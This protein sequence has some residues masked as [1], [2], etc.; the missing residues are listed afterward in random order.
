MPIGVRSGSEREPDG[1]Q[2]ALAIGA[3]GVVFGDIG[4]SP[5]Y[6]I[7]TVFNPGDP[8]PI[9]ATREGVFGVVSL[10]F[11]AV[12]LIVTVTYAKTVIMGSRIEV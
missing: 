6:T 9:E 2:A 1:A 7:Q 4:T 5:L 10:V 11:W 3:L 12:T 8:H